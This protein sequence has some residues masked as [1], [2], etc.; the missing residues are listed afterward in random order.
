MFRLAATCVPLLFG[1]ALLGSF[2]VLAQRSDPPP[3]QEVRPIA[4]PQTGQASGTKRIREGTALRNA[5]VFFLQTGDRTVLYTV[6]NNQRFTCLEN[7]ALER[8]LTTMREKPE[9][10]FWKING[11]FTEFRGENFVII[12]HAVIAP[13]QSVDTSVSP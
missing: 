9:R 7:L 6:E 1:F 2:V 4:V 8:I 11:E 5:H 13:A 12:R 3:N 10:K